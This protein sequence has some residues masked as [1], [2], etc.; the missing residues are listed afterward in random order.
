MEK[1]KSEVNRYT[2]SAIDKALDVI[3]T[4]ADQEA[5]SLLE[6]SELLKRPKSSI[7]RIVLT[8]EN[9]GYVTRSEEN[10]KYTLGYKQLTIARKLLTKSSLRGS[11][12]HE[13]K[14]L[15]D[16][17]GDTVNLGVLIGGDVLYIDMIEGSHSLRMNESIGSTSPFHA[18]AIGKA[19]AALRYQN[20]FDAL[21]ELKPLQKITI[22]TITDIGVFRKE[23]TSVLDKGYA[24]DDEESVQGARC[25]AAPV[26]NLSGKVE[27]AISIS[28]AIHR[29]SMNEVPGIADDVKKAA[30][31]ISVKLGY[32]N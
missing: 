28:G 7:Y 3:E 8:L 2:I 1:N 9:R 11:A 32:A 6:L 31:N 22:N 30:N 14:W 21:L 25:I 23:L 10:E 13:M 27:E 18:T 24:V 29:Y 12:Y 15:S 26:F 4:L 20:N 5:L 16:K 19:I 17:Y